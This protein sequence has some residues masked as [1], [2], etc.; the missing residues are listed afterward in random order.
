MSP[1]LARI[2]E[3]A[4]YIFDDNKMLFA[5]L[6]GDSFNDIRFGKYEKFEN[7]GGKVPETLAGAAKALYKMVGTEF[8]NRLTAQRI[9][10]VIQQYLV[11][12]MPPSEFRSF[13]KT[14][15]L[16]FPLR[17]YQNL[18]EWAEDPEVNLPLLRGSEPS[19]QPISIFVTEGK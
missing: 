18:V 15:P 6:A 3:I 14:N 2:S 12:L 9:C 1:E 5:I 16:R 11:R 8:D 7:A 4:K 17:Y 13:V 19:A 10:Y